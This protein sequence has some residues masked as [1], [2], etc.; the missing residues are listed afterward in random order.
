MSIHTK[1][2]FEY[3]DSHPVS[4]YEG[5]FQSLLEMLHYIYT[6]CNPI[7]SSMIRSGFQNL[8]AAMER[9]P[10]E[11]QDDLFSAAYDLCLQHQQLAFAHGLTVGMHLLT[12][13]NGLP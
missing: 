5:D 10:A 8:R 1:D 6:A 13:I 9:L 11:D 7:D 4:L 3:L 2:V 12:E